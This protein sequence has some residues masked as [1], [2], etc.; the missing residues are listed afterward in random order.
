MY[1]F[2]IIAKIHFLKGSATGSYAKG[3]KRDATNGFVGTDDA[4]T[5]GCCV[6]GSRAG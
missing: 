3:E 4:L 6:D 2:L 5:H 1:F